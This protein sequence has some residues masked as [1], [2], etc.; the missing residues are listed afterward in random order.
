[1]AY[2]LDHLPP[3]LHLI[4]ATRADPPLP[5]ARLRARGQLVE[6][7]LVDLRIV[8]DDRFLEPGDD[9]GLTD[10]DTAALL[11]RTE[12]WIAG[13]QIAAI[14]AAPVR[15]LHVYCDF[16]GSHRYVLI[17]KKRCSNGSQPR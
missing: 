9:L 10:T 13:L 6:L 17:T 11:S 15:R 2:L 12:G 14:I 7:R 8:R 5:L 16:T 4:I 1:L 3:N